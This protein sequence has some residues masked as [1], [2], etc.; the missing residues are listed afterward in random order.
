MSV[1]KDFYIAIGLVVLMFL[2]PFAPGEWF[3][4]VAVAGILVTWMDTI[5][6]I[7]KSN[8]PCCYNNQKKR[9]ANVFI[10]L[11]LV[12]L[13]LFILMIV[14]LAVNLK[15][16]NNPIILDELTLVA[17]LICLEQN[18]IIEIVNS[19]IQKGLKR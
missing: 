8:T 5:S 14:N 13:V 15:W 17:L 6:K 3:G 12:G 19:Y 16:L 1:I 2:R 10:V 9:Y 4:S 7:W 11:G 18:R